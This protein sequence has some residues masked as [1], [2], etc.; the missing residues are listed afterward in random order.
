MTDIVRIPFH[1]DDLLAV[2]VDGKPH[3][4][5]KP[6][7]EALGLAYSSQLQ[8]LQGKSWATMSLIDMVGSDGRVRD[9]VTVDVRTFLMLLAG[10]QEARVAAHVKPK[11]IAYQ[12]EV[13]DVIEAHFTRETTSSSHIALPQTYSDAL[14]AL[15]DQVEQADRLQLAITAQQAKIKE[16]EPQAKKFREWQ[17]SEDTVYVGEWAKSIGLTRDRAYEILRDEGVLFRQRKF[18]GLGEYLNLPIEK[19]AHL[20]DVVDEPRGRTGRWTKVSKLFPDG[21]V[22]LAELLL[23]RGYIQPRRDPN[24]Q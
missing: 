11:L 10:V 3:I 24:D 13:A 7:I 22:E 5:L 2:L 12:A 23:S 17:I 18:G 8:K 4:V 14:R 15:A 6:A 1:G 9:M 20:F 19:H 16:L 21:Q